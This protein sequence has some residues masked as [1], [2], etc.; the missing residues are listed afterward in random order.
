MELLRL[1]GCRADRQWIVVEVGLIGRTP[2][3]GSCNQISQL[4]V[5]KP[6]KKAD[7]NP[8]NFLPM[9]CYYD[10]K[11]LSYQSVTA[12]TMRKKPDKKPDKT[13]VKKPVPAARAKSKSGVVDRGEAVT[14]ME[15]MT[16]S[17]S[18][19]HRAL[20]SDTVLQLTQRAATFRSRLPEGLI[21][22]LSSLV[23]EMNCYYSNLIE[24]HNT[25]PVDI[26]RALFGEQSRDPK[27]RDLQQEAV[28]HI[29]VQRWIDEGGLGQ[30]PTT[31]ASVL[32]IHR[33]FYEALP[34]NLKWVEN[35]DTGEREAVVPG[36]PRHKNVEVGRLVA[37]SP[38]AVERHLQRW[39]HS[40]AALGS[41]ESA[42][43]TAAAH[44]RLLW[45]HPFLDGNGRVARLISY[46]TLRSALDTCGLWS[47]ARGLARDAKTYKG[48][49]AACDA[50]RRNDLDGRGN[51]SEENLVDF[52]QYFL[53]VCL[54]QIDFMEG[55]MRPKDLRAR[56]MAWADDEIRVKR[57]HDKA[58]VIL[59]HILFDGSLERKALPGLVGMDE[60]QARR[61]AQPLVQIGL[62][63]SISTRAPYQLAFPAELAPRI[64]PGLYPGT[65]P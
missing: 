8:V 46:A 48:H 55:L 40:Y 10:M 34:D 19:R 60:R 9:L 47:V 42:L 26:Q 54:D 15:P 43:N 49:L 3:G 63:R 32:E 6:D 4:P 36:Q 41:F 37:V 30:K 1:L 7:K 2:L 11:I 58:K 28:A 27:K 44:H 33:R 38:G 35:P 57:L 29:A 16:I 61:V 25:H 20:L 12:R 5:N 39:E 21:E 18:S 22:P 24:G 13:A 53:D 23:R 59:D 45:I 52:T 31:A 50:Q 14:G 64:M 17:E 62:I 51:L 56:I 65:L